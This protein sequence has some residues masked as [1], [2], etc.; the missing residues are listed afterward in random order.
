MIWNVY[1][2]TVY[3]QYITFPTTFFCVQ[4]NLSP[5]AAAQFDTTPPLA[6]RLEKSTRDVSLQ[7]VLSQR[8][9]GLLNSPLRFEG[10]GSA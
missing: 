1:V 9:I 3:V 10:F 7:D 6:F 2:F 4:K 8:T 5:R